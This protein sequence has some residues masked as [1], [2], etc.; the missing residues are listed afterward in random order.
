MVEDAVKKAMVPIQEQ[1]ETI[2]KSRSLPNNLNDEPV[3]GG[4]E[5]S[6]QHYLHGIL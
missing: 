5:K 6:E 1:L 3:N 4:L 2:R